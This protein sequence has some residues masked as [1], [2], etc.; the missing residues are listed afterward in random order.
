M[1]TK[2]A[3]IT[4]I[5]I[6]PERDRRSRMIQYGIAMSIRVVC[7]VLCL[8]T[9]GWWLLIPAAGAIFLPYVAVVIA[10]NVHRTGTT[11]TRPGA[12]ARRDDAPRD[13]PHAGPGQP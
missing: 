9:P 13:V 7:I 4:E 11:V 3:S 2:P 12:L 6:S 10:N 1:R 8:V 5:P